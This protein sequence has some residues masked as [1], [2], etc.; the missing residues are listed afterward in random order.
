MNESMTNIQAMLSSDPD[1]VYPPDTLES[2]CLDQKQSNELDLLRAKIRRYFE[3]DRC[4][5]AM[6]LAAI[7]HK[8]IGY[9]SPT[10]EG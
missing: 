4:E 6:R 3:T 8:L 7:A 10:R 2:V 1:A 9:G 5:E